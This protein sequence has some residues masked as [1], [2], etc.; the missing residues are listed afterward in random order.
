MSTTDD[1]TTRE[2]ALVEICRKVFKYNKHGLVS[3]GDMMEGDDLVA[4]LKALRAYDH[5]KPKIPVM[6]TWEE[7]I[8]RNNFPKG[9]SGD[10]W[11]RAFKWARANGMSIYEEQYNTIR[12]LTAKEQE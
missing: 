5:P 4:V 6:P 3:P 8:A 11:G 10:V 7:F 2:K 1:L 12:E 9:V